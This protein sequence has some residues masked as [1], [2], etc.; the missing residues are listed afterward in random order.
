MGHRMDW[1]GPDSV[2]S[3]VWLWLVTFGVQR[4]RGALGG[5][6]G[7]ES[8]RDRPRSTTAIQ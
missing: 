1:D 5:R 8:G 7:L 4:D 2:L 6:S 3:A